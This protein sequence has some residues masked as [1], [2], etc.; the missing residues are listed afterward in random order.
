MPLSCRGPSGTRILAILRGDRYNSFQY[1]GHRQDGL[2]LC[3]ILNDRL[4]SQNQIKTEMGSWRTR[5]II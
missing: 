2:R 4:W 5:S 1:R 3:W